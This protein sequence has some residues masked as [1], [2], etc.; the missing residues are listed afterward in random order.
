[1]RSEERGNED[2]S[3]TMRELHKKYGLLG[4]RI[5]RIIDVDEDEH[6]GVCV[7]EEFLPNCDMLAEES[8]TVKVETGECIEILLSEIVSIDVL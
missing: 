2:M 3:L 5:L 7:D 1:M 8:V 6:Q 4:G